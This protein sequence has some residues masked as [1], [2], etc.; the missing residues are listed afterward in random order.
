MSPRGGLLRP[1]PRLTPNLLSALRG[2]PGIGDVGVDVMEFGVTGHGYPTDDLAATQAAVNAVSAAGG[3]TVVWPTPPNKY[4]F[5]GPL[6]PRPNV[7]FLGTGFDCEIEGRGNYPLIANPDDAA[8]EFFF[9]EGLHLRYDGTI[10]AGIGGGA[11]NNA[12][13]IEFKTRSG[14]YP[15]RYRLV[16]MVFTDCATGYFDESMSWGATLDHI[17]TFRCRTGIYKRGAGGTGTLMKF[18]NCLAKGTVGEVNTYPAGWDVKGW[19]L[20]GGAAYVLDTCGL[21]YYEGGDFAYFDKV[22]G[23][24]L[25]GF[26][27]EENDVKSGASGIRFNECNALVINGMTGRSNSLTCNTG[28]SCRLVTLQGDT[29]ASNFTSGVLNGCRFGGINGDTRSGTGSFYTLAIYGSSHVVI[30]GGFINRVE[31]P[32]GEDAIYSIYK[33]ASNPKGSVVL[34]SVPNDG[35]WGDP[36]DEM[37]Y[38]TGADGVLGT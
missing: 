5:S 27:F 4:Y 13:G 8:L 14:H 33:H 29:G 9:I 18:N 21:E 26:Y 12:N 23:L 3:G 19:D 35:H 10:G 15:R 25:N 38:I 37:C 20:D 1:H 34:I 7:N 17:Q 36:N 28:Y 16:D 30:N 31:A 6:Y 11:W 24:T 2:R 32:N 22:E